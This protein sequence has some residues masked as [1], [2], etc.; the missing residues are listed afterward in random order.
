MRKLGKYQGVRTRTQLD[1]GVLARYFS[2]LILTQLIIF[3]LLGV[4]FNLI[5]EIIV[6]VGK[7]EGAEAVLKSFSKLPGRI[8]VSIVCDVCSKV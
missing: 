5:T 2:F 4:V 8:Q 7:K 1:R 3:S 6:E